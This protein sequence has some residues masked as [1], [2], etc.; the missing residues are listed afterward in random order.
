M[1][2]QQVSIDMSKL[3]EMADNQIPQK[4]MAATLGVSAPTLR[5][6]IAELRSQQGIILESKEVENLRVIK[7][8]EKV[9]SRIER[10]MPQMDSDDLIKTLNVLNKMDKPK[11]ADVKMQG[12]LGLLTAIDDEAERRSDIKVEEKMLEENTVEVSSFPNL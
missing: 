7:L 2:R 5:D 10:Q 1:G 3:L 12:L 4:E 9:L 11:E 6:R 8:K